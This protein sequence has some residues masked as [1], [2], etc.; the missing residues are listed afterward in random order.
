M[1]GVTDGRDRAKA[2]CRQAQDKRTLEVMTGHKA[3]V[4][5]SE[6]PATNLAWLSRLNP[7]ITGQEVG[8]ANGG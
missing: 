4:M 1:E 2:A 8:G 5:K 7:S 3:T 6:L